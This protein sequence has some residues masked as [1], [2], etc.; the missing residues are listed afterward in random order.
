MEAVLDFNYMG[1]QFVNFKIVKLR[2]NEIQS[3]SVNS[4]QP[5]IPNASMGIWLE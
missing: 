3:L 2:L 5:V 1:R 4:P